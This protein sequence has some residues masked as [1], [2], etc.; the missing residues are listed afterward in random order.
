M[1]AMFLLA[2]Y[3]NL[4]LLN[5]VVAQMEKTSH[6]ELISMYKKILEYLEFLDLEKSKLEGQKEGA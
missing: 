2:K 1:M 6:K 3:Q 4:S 5:K